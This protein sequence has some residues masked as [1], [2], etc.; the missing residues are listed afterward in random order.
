M[1]NERTVRCA[2]GLAVLAVGLLAL[3]IPGCGEKDKG[4][5]SK[6]SASRPAK[7]TVAVVNAVCPIMGNKI[8]PGKVPAN[9][10]REYKDKK[11]GFCCPMCLSKWDK[12]TDEKKDEL[13]AKMTKG[14]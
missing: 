2:L 3:G 10:V 14:P 12:L 11:V 4:P 7:A 6:P 5:A 9:L 13:L 8:D 1:R